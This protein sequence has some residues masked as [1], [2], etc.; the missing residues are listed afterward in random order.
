[1]VSER[2]AWLCRRPTAGGYAC[3]VLWHVL[4]WALV[5]LPLLLWL[6]LVLLPLLLALLALL[7][8]LFQVQVQVLFQ[9]PLSVLEPVPPR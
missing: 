9:V 4:T 2:A 6:A 1:M 3:W 5:L 7:Q 8:V